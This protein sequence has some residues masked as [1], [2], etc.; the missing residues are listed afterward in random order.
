[1]HAYMIQICGH[2]LT[3]DVATTTNDYETKAKEPEW[4]WG[5]HEHWN[6]NY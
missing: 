5:M 3:T 6:N 2:K 1:M 4:Y